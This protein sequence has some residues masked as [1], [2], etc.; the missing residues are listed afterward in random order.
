[1]SKSLFG[2]E[3]MLNEK[4]VGEALQVVNRM[5]AALSTANLTQ[6]GEN[7]IIEGDAANAGTEGTF[8]LIFN[9]EGRCVRRLETALSETIGFDGVTGWAVDWTGMPRTLG[10]GELEWEQLLT[11]LYTGLWLGEKSLFR[12][13]SLT[14][15]FAGEVILTVIHQNGLLQAEVKVD[16]AS[17]RV[18]SVLH[19]GIRGKEILALDD[20][21]QVA[22]LILPGR[23]TYS[24]NGIPAATFKVR[25]VSRQ[26][27]AADN[28]YRPIT[29][30]PDD[31]RFHHNVSPRLEVK[32]AP[33]GHFLIRAKINA[34][35]SGWFILD[36]GASN[37]VV[38]CETAAR[39]QLAQAGTVPL[40]SMF[41]VIASPVRRADRLEVGPLV[42][43]RPN[44]VEMDLAPLDQVLGETLAGIIG[45]DLFSRAIVEIDIADNAV[46]IHDPSAYALSAGKWQE[47][48][49]QYQTPVIRAAFDGDHDRWFRV[50]IGAAVTVMFHTPTVRAL[51][52]LKNHV[53]TPARFGELEVIF[54][55]LAWFEVAGHRFNNPQVILVTNANGPGAD[56]FTAGNL[57]LEFL[58]PFRLIFDYANKRVAL[59]ENAN[60]K[61]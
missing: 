56:P 27:S 60:G 53:G 19:D 28:F 25:S 54:G 45:Y 46:S 24:V 1:M 51:D 18:K 8:R 10:T 2:A 11:G 14:E 15:N 49:I 39:L 17:W 30:R 36:T 3:S 59:I 22:G 55:N 44:L 6:D 35:A 21:Q 57:G 23:L 9:A 4:P 52:L 43:R 41:G 5:R 29:S 12:I 50:D 48:M 31:V 20:Y 26:S 33:T 61:K 16:P 42:L 38:A 47:L 37:S 13:V 7:I 34:Q 58:K 40:T 32:R